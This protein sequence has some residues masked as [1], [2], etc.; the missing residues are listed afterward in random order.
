SRR[1][2]KR[3]RKG[4]RSMQEVVRL[5]RDGTPPP[6]SRGATSTPDL[7]QYWWVVRDRWLLICSIAAIMV[8]LGLIYVL[9]AQHLYTASGTL[10]IDPRKNQLMQSQHI[11]NE[12]PFDANVV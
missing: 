12:I 1:L 3:A 5:E 6:L 2:V 11:M 8:A 10:L 4:R 9:T 7:M